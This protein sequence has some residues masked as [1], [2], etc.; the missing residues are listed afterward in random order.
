MILPAYA[1][2]KSS[3]LP[4]P[5]SRFLDPRS[6]DP[7]PSR[8]EGPAPLR[9]LALAGLA[10]G[11]LCLSGIGLPGLSGA[12]LA[13]SL[14][15]ETFADLAAK[16][17]P[18][19]VNISST[20]HEAAASADQTMPFDFPPG[21]PFEEF[22]KHF[23]EQQGR[24]RGGQD[25]TAL[26]SG[27]LI[28]PSGYIVTNDHVIDGATEI[29][30]TLAG[31]K[32]YPAKLIGADKKT[33]LALLKIDAGSPLPYVTWGNSDTMR[34]GDWVLAVGN[35]FGLGGTVTTGIISARSRDIHSGPFDDFL[36][37]DASINRGN[38][39]G[40]TF[41]LVGEVIGINSA[42]ASPNGGSV[43][44]GF[45]IP[46]NMARPVIE[47]LRQRGRVDRGWI[48][49][50]IQEVTPELAQS[51]GLGA[52]TGALIA[53]VQ[54]DGPAA[55][56]A[57]QQGDV[58]LSFDGQT[59]GET[60]ELPRI[61]AGTPA[62]KQVQLVIWRNGARKTLSLTVAKMKDETQV[63]SAETPPSTPA[64]SPSRRV[65]GVQLSALTEDLRQQLGLSDD[66]RGVVITDIADGSP[67][68]RQGLQQ[69]DIIEQVAQRKVASPGEV[70]RL[71]E[72]A[73]KKNAASVLLLVNR[74]GSE[75]FLA[76]KVGK[77]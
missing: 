13:A 1:D 66:I 38:S 21:S 69:G 54:P 20:H 39:G 72:Q 56:A 7:G 43:G 15:P 37:I 68:A 71:V 12:A 31:G 73:V 30:A 67:A 2:R 28:D 44:I 40:P 14:P 17:T 11:F 29:H 65:L 32:D 10:L 58:I 60:R 33:D 25:M 62:G 42:I 46:S 45:A 61:V 24:N 47:A 57:L 22:F 49:V 36:Q 3:P 9:R 34:V 18:A 16:V 6:S 63:S 76:V 4:D 50:A 55:A 26:G 41:N 8:A 70:D 74:Q 59:V 5:E 48:G 35:P 77:A 64:E 19:V 27:F 75:L 52:P 23:R 51:L 53:S